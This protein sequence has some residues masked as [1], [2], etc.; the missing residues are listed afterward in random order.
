VELT[1]RRV[2]ALLFC[3]CVAAEGCTKAPSSTSITAPT[4]VAVATK[5]VF[6]VQPANGV[7]GAAINPAILVSVTDVSGKVVTTA[8]STVSISI[9][10]NPSNAALGGSL[11]VTAVAGVATFSN[12]ELFRSGAGYTFVASSPGLASATSATFNV[13]TGATP[14]FSFAQFS[15]G[16]NSVCGIT[17]TGSSYCWGANGDMQLG[18]GAANNAT[19]FAPL[20]VAT[21]LA[22]ASVSTGGTFS[23]GVTAGHAAYCWGDNFYGEL[24]TG[25]LVSSGTPVA[26]TGGLSFASVSVGGSTACGLTAAGIAYCWG[27][28]EQGQLGNGLDPVRDSV[29]TPVLGG[30]LFTSLGMGQSSACGV[31]TSG[32]AYCWGVGPLGTAAAVTGSLPAR[33]DGGL[34][35]SGV[36]VATSSACG[37]TIANVAYCWGFNNAGQLGNGNFASTNA[38]V[39]VSGG[40]AFSNVSAGSAFACGVTTAGAAYCWGN[41]ALGQLGNGSTTNSNVPVAVSGGLTFQSVSAGNV[42]ACGLTTAN[43]IYCWGA[44]GTGQLGNGS[45]TNS[46]VPVKVGGN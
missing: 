45:S 41:N 24:A 31:T 30:L 17:P 2:G 38:P 14:T 10:S 23:C 27:V 33:V 4:P 35:F 9:G 11:T 29:P 18:L 28:G 39:A 21:T 13:T 40:L 37:V 5:L 16:E 6:S 26:V 20:P 36:S 34:T 15:S 22:F 7:A 44:N 12:L 19:A 25:A 46:N 3:M 8:D 1:N 32:A 43:A 42:F